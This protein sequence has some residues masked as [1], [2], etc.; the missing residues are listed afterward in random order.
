[1]LLLLFRRSFAATTFME[2]GFQLL[3]I[4]TDNASSND[5]LL[6]TVARK[7]N[8][9]NIDF[10]EHHNHARCL[11]HIVNLAAKAAIQLLQRTNYRAESTPPPHSEDEEQENSSL[12]PGDDSDVGDLTAEE[13]D[14]PIEP[15]ADS[16]CM[17]RG[18]F[19]LACY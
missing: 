2:F 4:G 17:W 1:V 10:D 7:L 19:S 15:A 9:K 11:A 12:S 8:A 18:V 14:E 5:T 3:A 13:L 6:S 16:V